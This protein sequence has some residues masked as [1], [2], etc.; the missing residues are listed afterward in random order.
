MVGYNAKILKDDSRIQKVEYLTQINNAPTD[1]A[2]VKETMRRSMQI[3]SECGKKFFNVTY[4]LA[5]AKIALRIQSAEDE[6]QK[7]FI[8]FG[9]FSQWFC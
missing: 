2:V 5:M 6:F 9:N 1:P 7:L 3:A 4:D 8:N